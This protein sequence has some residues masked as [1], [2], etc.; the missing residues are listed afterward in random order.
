MEII[1]QQFTP[2]YTHTNI[3]ERG[4]EDYPPLVLILYDND[5][6]TV[7]N[8]LFSDIATNTSGS[9]GVIPL[10]DNSVGAASVTIS[11]ST[12]T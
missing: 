5:V 2:S 10:D 8:S 6:V 3:T 4:E 7:T 12:F 11:Q 1:G 9:I